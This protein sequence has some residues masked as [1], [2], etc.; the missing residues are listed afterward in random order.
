M[1]QE[2]TPAAGQ[3]PP[4]RT[5]KTTP[6]ASPAEA[7]TGSQEKAPPAGQKPPPRTR[8]AG[9]P[10]RAS[11]P[12]DGGTPSPGAVGPGGEIA[13][14]RL[15]EQIGQGGMAIV[16]RAHDERLGRDVALKLL[17][18]GFAADSEFRRRFIRESRAAAAADHPN[19]IPIYDA[20]DADGALF[21][22]MRYVHGGDVGSL[23]KRDGPLSAAR[24]W[25]IISQVAEALDAAHARG[26][27]HRD[28]K[29][30]N[31]L[32]DAPATAAGARGSSPAG[33]P[34][35]VYL[36]DFGIS[37]QPLST[38]GRITMT[39]QFVG[40]LDY[41]APEQINGRDVDGRADLYSLGCA[42]FELL[43]G[44]PPFRRGPALAAINAHLSE[45]PPSLTARRAGLPAAVD[46]VLAAA[47]AKSPD[48]RYATCAQFATDLGRALGLVPGEPDLPS[49]VSQPDT[50]HAAQVP[51][52]PAGPAPDVAPGEQ[53]GPVGVAGAAGL[54]EPAGPGGRYGTKP[55]GPAGPYGPYGP[56]GSAGQ[57]QTPAPRSRGMLTGVVAVAAAAAVV[58]GAAVAVVLVSRGG[59]SS[60]PAPTPTPTATS[61]APSPTPSPSPSAEALAVSNLL[62]SGA[63]SSVA[64][65]NAADNVAACTDLPH[66]VQQIQQVRDQRQAEYDQAQKLS[67]GALRGGAEVKA[68]LVQALQDSLNADDDYLSWARQQAANCQPGSQSSAALA[69][70]RQAVA[71]KTKFVQLWNPIAAQYGLPSISVS[72]I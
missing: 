37:K 51:A 60:P 8:S 5:R 1:S 59:V 48:Q 67:T 71:D 43:S 17:A 49:A 19:I 31:M 23:L 15:E 18:P 53:Q 50:I 7:A 10:T 72:S 21:I 34:D 42:A 40:T 70:D 57:P 33:Q 16:Y 41:I 13:G 58:A 44:T 56:A 22:A 4:S 9:P 20:G 39:G 55:D 30:A 25:A 27:I 61:Q 68:D 62:M 69:A 12:K 64:L 3:K 2:E 14:Y 24:A 6:Q 11:Q 52:P 45:P 66:S 32:L 46:G 38:S 35:H 28:V 63:N 65:T 26:L 29:P 54:G 36:S 47:M